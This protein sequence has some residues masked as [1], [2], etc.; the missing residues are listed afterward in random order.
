MKTSRTLFFLPI[1]STSFFISITRQTRN[2]R[3][4]TIN[5]LGWVS[6]SRSLLSLSLVSYLECIQLMVSLKSLSLI[7]PRPLP[8]T[9]NEAYFLNDL[10]FYFKLRKYQ[11]VTAIQVCADYNT[12]KYDHWWED[13]IPSCNE[14][15]IR[16]LIRDSRTSS[17]I[18]LYNKLL[19]AVLSLED[20]FTNQRWM[21]YVTDSKSAFRQF[22]D[23]ELSATFD[24]WLTVCILIF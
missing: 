21:V 17:S 11:E 1:C 15:F 3:F 22:I 8:F 24:V 19:N 18:S 10:L 16:S 2:A 20:T 9:E 12:N 13:S 5:I 4:M 6:L 14:K 7:T 23:S